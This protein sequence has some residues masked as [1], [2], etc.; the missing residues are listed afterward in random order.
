MP[1]DNHTLPPVHVLQN[2]SDLIVL[3]ACECTSEFQKNAALIK[4]M[5]DSDKMYTLTLTS[6]VLSPVSTGIMMI[7]K[8]VISRSDQHLGGHWNR[9]S[10][11]ALRSLCLAFSFTPWFNEKHGKDSTN[12][13][14]FAKDRNHVK[15]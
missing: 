8:T 4:T 1:N 13:L 5:Y 9:F 6:R 10:L 7:S 11:S 15:I 14:S 2:T 12:D 3:H